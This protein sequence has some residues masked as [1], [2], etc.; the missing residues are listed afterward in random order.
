MDIEIDNKIRDISG[1]TNKLLDAYKHIRIA[2]NVLQEGHHDSWNKLDTSQYKKLDT[3]IKLKNSDI[4]LDEN[5]KFSYWHL[6]FL[7]G[8]YIFDFIYELHS[9]SIIEKKNITPTKQIVASG[10]SEHVNIFTVIF[11]L[12]I[13]IIILRIQ[14]NNSWLVNSGLMNIHI[15]RFLPLIF[16]CM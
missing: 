9:L 10:N 14:N 16:I 2:N 12:L 7:T 6:D 8:Y 5:E 11:N 13:L 1:D 3:F 4:V 15:N